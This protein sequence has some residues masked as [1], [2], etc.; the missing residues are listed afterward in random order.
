[1]EGTAKCDWWNDW[2]GKGLLRGNVGLRFVEGTE[3]CYWWTDWRVKGLF[4]G[5]C[6]SEMCGGY[7]EMRLVDWLK[8]KGVVK[9]VMWVWDVWSLQRNVIVGLNEGRRRSGMSK[10]MGVAKVMRIWRRPSAIQVVMEQKETE[11]MK[12]C[13]SLGSLIRYGEDVQVKWNG[14]RCTV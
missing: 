12:H 2:R 8:G 10:D 14:A 5:Q 6:G 3:K 9:G 13:S 4:K 1:V 11:N 7:S